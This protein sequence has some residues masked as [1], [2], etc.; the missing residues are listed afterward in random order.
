MAEQS[1]VVLCKQDKRD[2]KGLEFPPFRCEAVP[3]FG[4]ATGDQP[5]GLTQ[6]QEEE[7]R[8]PCVISSLRGHSWATQ[9]MIT[10]LD[11]SALEPK[12]R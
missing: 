11:L 10:P 5:K 3:F 4:F 6:E 2:V 9:S 1:L 7:L 8:Y 12:R